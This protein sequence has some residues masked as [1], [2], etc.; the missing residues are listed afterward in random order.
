MNA[1]AA[2]YAARRVGSIFIYTNE[3]HP[4]E[5]YPHL[6]ALEQKYRHAAALRD[7]LGV[8]RPVMLDALDGACHRAYGMMPNMTWIF[9]AGG[10]PIYKSDWSDARSVESAIEYFLDVSERRR[11]RENLAPFRV[12]RL[13]YR[14]RDRVAFFAGLERAGPRAV[15]EYRD[16]FG[17]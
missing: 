3:A 10:L 12:E 5:H 6:T 16:A 14:S 1:I 15:Q 8:T 13:D 4:G 17:E 7:L 9:T 11:A 2:R